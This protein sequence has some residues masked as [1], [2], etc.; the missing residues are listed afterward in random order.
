MKTKKTTIIIIFIILLPFLTAAQWVSYNIDGSGFR[1]EFPQKATNTCVNPT[2]WEVCLTCESSMFTYDFRYNKTSITGSKPNDK[3]IEEILLSAIE[4]YASERNF[5]I[6]RNEPIN[7]KDW[8]NG[9]KALQI[10]M[11]T[12]GLVHESTN[13][14]G[15]TTTVICRSHKC[16]VKAFYYE[17]HIFVLA[18]YSSPELPPLKTVLKFWNSLKKQ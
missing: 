1:V 9:G 15:T 17:T 10:E 18:V 14:E 12:F 8:E 16:R 7:L 2:E 5:H 3:E 11:E 4:T 6:K 13:L